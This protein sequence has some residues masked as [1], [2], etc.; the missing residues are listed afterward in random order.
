VARY[1]LP[2]AAE[3]PLRVVQLFVNSVD[4]EHGR[5]WLPSPEALA[6]WFSERGLPCEGAVLDA[7]LERAHALRDALRRLL[8]ANN[9]G[10]AGTDAIAVVN[11]AATRGGL[12]LV[13]DDQG[14]AVVRVRDPG[15]DGALARVVA[16][17]F[18]AMLDGSWVRLKACRQCEWVF[19]DTSKN[20]SGNWCSMQL[21]GNRRKTRA[22][23]QRRATE[24][25]E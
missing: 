19:W 7:H 15:A 16:V 2:R 22:Y 17:A 20:R 5:E 8:R 25:R 18:E 21:C 10:S 1:D 4:R 24:R 11:E 23:R 14:H 12:E 13:L 9:D 3:G 6:A